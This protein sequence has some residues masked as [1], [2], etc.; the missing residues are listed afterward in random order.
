M[1]KY[2]EEV[3]ELLELSRQR[4]CAYTTRN[5]LGPEPPRRCRSGWHSRSIIDETL[6]LI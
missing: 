3:K 4:A 1:A 6:S 2:T 5:P